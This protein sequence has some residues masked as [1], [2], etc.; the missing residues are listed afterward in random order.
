M[1]VIPSFRTIFFRGLRLRD[2]MNEYL[3]NISSS[4]RQ[5]PEE[6][7]ILYA[8]FAV[9]GLLFFITVLLATYIA[10]SG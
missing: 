7:A 6:R 10:I 5:S 3:E 8:L 2:E 4:T 9:A 1:P